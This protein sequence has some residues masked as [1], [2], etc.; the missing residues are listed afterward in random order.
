MELREGETLASALQRLRGRVHH[1]YRR[2]WSKTRPGAYEKPSYRKRKRQS[3]RNRNASL[4]KQHAQQSPAQRCT[5]FLGLG[6]LFSP[7]EPFQRKRLPFKPHRRW[8][9]DD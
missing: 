5:V 4:A 9:G 8:W 2:Q 6:L 1:A 3:L 7:A